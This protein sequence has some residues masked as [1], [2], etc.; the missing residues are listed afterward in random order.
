MPQ[1]R[2]QR[3]PVYRYRE[4]IAAIGTD[5]EVQEMI[6]ASGFDPPPAATIRG[7]RTRNSVPSLWVPLLIAHAM[8][9][10]KLRDPALL[11]Q[12]GEVRRRKPGKQPQQSGAIL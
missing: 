6:Q 9:A 1:H 7:W 12:K 4:L 2:E 11:L 5:L 10:G 8:T 3:Q